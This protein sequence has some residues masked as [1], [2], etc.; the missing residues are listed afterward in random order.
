MKEKFYKLA[1]ILAVVSFLPFLI[2]VSRRE[3]PPEKVKVPQHKTQTVENFKL[4]ATG[5]NKWELSAPKATFIG[6]N[7]IKLI[8][9]VLTVY[10]QNEIIIKSSSAVLYRD[11]GIVY[12]DNVTLVGRNFRASSKKGTY[13]LKRQL[14]ETDEGCRAVYNNVNS[15]EGEIC[16]IDVREDKVIILKHVKTVIREV[17]K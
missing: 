7:V 15:L 16:K 5:E 14:F 17:S 2:F 10:L 13:N 6:K 4:K 11:R 3:A 9:P 12:L 1:L 8:L